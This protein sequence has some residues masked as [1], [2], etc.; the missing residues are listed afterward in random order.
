MVK[1]IVTF[2]LTGS[3]EERLQVARNFKEALEALPEQIDVLESIEVGINENP[4]EEWDV[5]LTAI[6]PSMADVAIYA[7][8]PAHVAA[9]GLLKG[10]KADR[11]CVDYYV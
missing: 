10:H 1:H 2:K 9:A 8:H 3:P 5:V 7:N 4:S 11:A 6:V